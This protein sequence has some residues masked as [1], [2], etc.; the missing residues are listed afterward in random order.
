MAKSDTVLPYGGG[1]SLD[2]PVFVPKGTV[3]NY[4]IYAMHRRVDLYGMDAEIFRPERWT[5]QLPI[6]EDD[7]TR[8]W[9]YL[10]FNGG[11]RTCPGKDFAF[12]G[13][14]YTIVRLIQ[15]NP[16]LRL[17][18]NEPVQVVGTEKQCANL[19]LSSANGCRVQM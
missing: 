12:E 7:T 9:G 16:N 2:R 10:P 3:I 11:L 19:V 14:M 17:P 18:L 4:S 8:Q 1:R 15:H 5:Q 13:A 6:S